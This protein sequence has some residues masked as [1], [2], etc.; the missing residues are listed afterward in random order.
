[1]F[2]LPASL[3]PELAPQEFKAF[4]RDQTRP[5]SLARRSSLGGGGST[6]LG[7]RK[8]TLRG[9]YK[10]SQGDGVGESK[11]ETIVE[12]GATGEERDAAGGGA[13]LGLGGVR[14]H[15]R[16]NFEE[17]TIDD[18]QRL[19]QLA[20]ELPDLRCAHA[21]VTY[22]DVSAWGAQRGPRRRVAKEARA[23]ANDLGAC[24]GEA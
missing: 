2:W 17:L 24:S 4:I 9:E 12:E 21:D 6:G 23:R 5:E 7:R 16:L 8:S 3:H 11:S 15:T 18:L 14:G 1:M 13:G 22:A 20:G 10:P 19:E